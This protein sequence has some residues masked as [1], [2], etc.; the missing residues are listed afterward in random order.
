MAEGRG[1]LITLGEEDAVR[2]PLLKI[3]DL[4]KM[5]KKLGTPNLLRSTKVQPSNRPHPVSS[6]ALSDT[7]SHLA[8]GLGDGTVL[9]YRNLDQYVFSPSTSL[10]SL[11]KPKT[12]H[13]SPTEPIT[14]LGFKE[15]S[16][17]TAT[18]GATPVPLAN[19]T[20]HAHTRMETEDPTTNAPQS[21]K[22]AQNLYL[23]IV[24]TNRVLAYQAT[25][26]G[27]GAAPAVV[28]EVGA[29]LG[30]A[31]MD[32]HKRGIVIARDE[33]VYVCGVGGRGTSIAYEGLKSSVHTHLNYLVM[34]TPPF[35]P[36]ASAASATVR[37]LA[38]R[39]TNPAESEVT[40]VT[41]LDLENKLV[42][43]SGTF[44]EGVR[45]VVSQWSK[46]YVLGND[47]KLSCLEEKPNS[48]K[49]EMLYRRSLFVMALSIA[50]TQHM[51][52]SSV[53]DIH[54]QYGDHLYAK[55]DYDGAMAQ[56]VQTIGWTQPSYVIRKF[57]D[58]QRIHNLVTYLQELHSLGLANA[59]HTTLLLNT[60][61]KL[62]DVTR[63]DSFI[64]T[65][66][67]R[68]AT[69]ADGEETNELPFDLDTAIRV[70][71]QAGYFDHASYLAKKYDRHED[72]LRIQ[73]EDAGNFGDALVYLRRLGPEAAESNLARYGRAMLES[74]PEETTQLLIDLCTISGTLELEPEEQ[75]TEKPERSNTGGPSYLSYLALGRGAAPLPPTLTPGTVTPPSPSIKTLK[76]GETGSG[77][78]D[79]LNESPRSLSPPPEK[80]PQPLKPR[81]PTVKRLSPRLYFAHFVD[82]MDHFIIFLETVAERRWGQTV[83]GQVSTAS[84]EPPTDEAADKQDQTA[85]WNTLLELYL[86]A[87]ASHVSESNEKATPDVFRDKA[88]RVLKS[89]TIPYDPT[90]A[91][92]LC[93]S[94]E[95]TPGLVLL[96]E[97]MGMFEDVLR[98]WM[99]RDKEGNTPD[100]SAQ[101]V[102]H[103]NKYG[104]TRPH[105]YPLVLRFLTSSPEI[106]SRHTADISAVLD[107]IDEEKIMPPLGV[108]QAL[109]RNGVASV[110]LVKQ[111][112][113]M[114]IKESREEIHTDQ[115]LISSYRLETQ[116]KLKQVEAL[117][118][119]E[120][121]RVFHDTE[122]ECPSC[123]RAH[124]VIQEIRRNNERMADQ[125]D[126]FLSEVQDSGFMAVA[127]GFGR[128]VLNFGRLET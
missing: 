38:A 23:F 109:S 71:R 65:E 19:E 102:Q 62:K 104:P 24:T 28:D 98:F 124:G 40:K 99:Y 32:W 55:G 48:A 14:A 122:T 88:L 80:A 18:N 61:T 84:L 59:D 66:S 85:V 2:S 42:A 25:G 97:R 79:S 41:L 87:P 92:I 120:A 105:L 106:L 44:A 31:V 78:D 82:H 26:R 81:A 64:K 63:L 1:I 127:S 77:H 69:N 128:G 100:A 7:L 34:V 43:Y 13:E 107:H 56:F 103:L 117:S 11:P 67:R 76:P 54:R 8:I 15:P 57:L 93:S 75:I 118:D 123:V 47:G 72:Y 101:V 9:L 116:A 21:A 22:E 90:H 50:R 27:S 16:T 46:V 95:Y 39:L 12:I 35:T 94:H 89:E 53:A 112:L 20:A 3:W 49:L 4:T 29:G 126:V 37:N 86:T 96:W 68:K 119:P 10:T 110:G 108:I 121:P 83:E 33:A 113:M 36:T 58:A 73:I 30:C 5:D 45:E 111:W 70:C 115:Q 114:R 51:E 6:I 17:L 91:L 60:Y 125:H 52:E 74:L